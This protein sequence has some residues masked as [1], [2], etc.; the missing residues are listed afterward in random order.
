MKLVGYARVSTVEQNLEMQI[1][2]LLKAA[3]C[4]EICTI[5]D[6]PVPTSSVLV[7]SRFSRN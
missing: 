3:G 5:T 4:S 2:A 7:C 1:V 6:Y